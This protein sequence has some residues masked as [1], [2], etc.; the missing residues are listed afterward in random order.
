ML[1]FIFV[2]SSTSSCTMTDDEDDPVAAAADE[3]ID[4]DSRTV[5]ITS[6]TTSLLLSAVFA[7]FCC[8]LYFWVAY[9]HKRHKF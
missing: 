6:F 3:A 1:P 8:F 5:R 7:S 4:S 2:P 9:D